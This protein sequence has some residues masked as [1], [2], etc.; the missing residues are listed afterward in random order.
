MLPSNA[1][2]SSPYKRLSEM[3]LASAVKKRKMMSTSEK[4]VVQSSCVKISNNIFPQTKQEEALF[5][6][7]LA[8]MIPNAAV[9]SLLDQFSDNFVAKSLSAEWPVN[10]GALYDSQIS[11]TEFS[12]DQML[13]KCKVVDISITN[14]QALF[15]EQETRNQ[16]KSVFWHK[17]RVG[18][19]T[20]SHFHSSCHTNVSKPS[21]CLLKTICCG[22]RTK[23]AFSC[24]AK[25]GQEKGEDSKK[26]VFKTYGNDA[27]E[28]QSYTVWSDFE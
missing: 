5:F 3:H 8:G 15:V 23:Q 17:S 4:D 21:V 27:H 25:D 22:D 9:L 19:I 13:D 24:A 20:A 18:R 28:L 14:N 12:Y 2:L 10:L 1:D 16:S 11:A 26:G 6:Q 7:D